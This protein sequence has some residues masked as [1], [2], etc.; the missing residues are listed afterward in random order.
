MSVVI[1]DY[2][3]G[4]LHSVAKAFALMAEPLRLP[5]DVTSDSEKVAV[6]S[7]I[8]L[9]GVGAF[10]DCVAGLSAI[11]GMRQVLEE[12]VLS[13]GIPFFGICVGMQM[14]LEKGLEHGE[15]AG[16]G[17]IKGEVVTLAPED[18]S[19]KIP[20]M[21]WNGLQLQ[22]PDH[23]VFAGIRH[24]DHVYFV[25]SYHAQCQNRGNC[26]ATTDYTQTISAC[27]GRDNMIGTQF[28]PE[29]SQKVG[30]RLIEN[31]LNM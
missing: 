31:F 5:V 27:V 14:M 23:P 20:H 2:G 6:A 17:W 7:H 8:V 12:R 24:D 9:P 26:L 28:H 10:G 29:K 25:H 16:L 30:L 18:T 15:H 3:S 22:Q 19:L 13:T 21:G 4:N 1:I 11:D